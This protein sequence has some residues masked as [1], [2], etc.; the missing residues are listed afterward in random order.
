MIRPSQPSNQPGL[1]AGAEPWASDG[2]IP[3][4]GTAWDLLVVG[5]GTAGIVAAKTAAGFGASVL[6]IE[7]ARTG[8]D[9]LWTGC[10]PSKALLAAAHAAADA[11]AAARLGVHVAAVQVDFGAVMQH[12][13]LSIA[14]IEPDDSPQT[15]RA[16]GVR[17]VH[18]DVCLRGASAAA[19]HTLTY[20]A[21]HGAGV[22]TGGPRDS[23]AV[24]TTVRFR[25]AVLATGSAPVMP[26]IPGLSDANPL[27]SDS[28][29]DLTELPGR[30][31]VLGGGSVGCELGQAFARLG[32][33]VS[34]VEA[35][36]NLVPGEDPLAAGLLLAA[37]A[38]DGVTVGNGASVEGIEGD[39]SAWHARLS[40]GDRIPFDRVLVAVGRTPRTR[41]LGLDSAGVEVGERGFVTVDARLRTTN[42]RIWAAGDV[43]G[44][45]QFTHVA[46]VHGA[47]AAANAVL[48]L[49][50]TVDTATIPR[51]TFTQPE[52]AAFGA[53]TAPDTVPKL[54]IRTVHHDTVDRAV[55]EDSRRGVTRLALDAK[56]RVVGA[57]IVGPRAGESLA[58]LVLAARHGL[59]GRDLAA[60]IHAYPTYG[61]AVWKAALADVTD[62]LHRPAMRL[63]TRGLS[64]RRRRR[65]R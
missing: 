60:A 28:I 50:R 58:E 49:R 30:L 61:D 20:R 65:M 2:L 57:T 36:P 1:A 24:G 45:P 23:A 27:T 37:L 10:V 39:G 8:G 18:G 64:R 15:L 25:Q 53:A 29:W 54:T 46:G 21:I 12:V 9:C 4:D 62:R 7:R 17:V 52:I 26:S 16:A 34:I 59:R 47:L 19:V 13:R 32:A 48:G 6:M 44:H 22:D 42:P 11:R 51:V 31:L 14:A 63:V 33:Q 38:E 35:A 43:T 40:N 41:G 55:A 56:G 5:G 3:P